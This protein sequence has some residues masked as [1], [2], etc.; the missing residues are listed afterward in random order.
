MHA[1][2]SKAGA[3]H[4]LM[5]RTFAWALVA[6]LLPAF[7]QSDD[8][9]QPVASDEQQAPESEPATPPASDGEPAP[10]QE[11]T[12][13]STDAHAHAPQDQQDET[14]GTIPVQSTAQ[15]A[16]SKSEPTQ[17]EEIVVT[18]TKREQ[19]LREIPQSIHAL[20]GD[21]LEK[22][23]IQTVA[24]IVKLTPGVNYWPDDG[25]RAPHI[26][27]RGISS[28]SDQNQTTGMIWENVSMTDT[29]PQLVTLDPN[30]FDLRSVEVLKG[31]Q[32]T[33]FGAGGFGGAV[34]FVPEPPVPGLWETKYFAQYTSVA[35]GQRAPIY[36]AAV[37]VPIGN[38]DKFALRL[39]G[40]RR[41]EPGFIDDRKLNQEDINSLDQTSLRGTLAWQPTQAWDAKLLYVHQTQDHP[42]SA[43]ADNRDGELSRGNIAIPEPGHSN[44]KM[45]NFS[46][47]YAFDWATFTSDSAWTDKD[48]F[49]VSDFSAAV[50][51]DATTQGL[52]F[53]AFNDTQLWS[54]ELRLVSP[55]DSDSSWK[56]VAGIFA[57][58]LDYFSYVPLFYGTYDNVVGTITLPVEVTEKAVFA[59]VTRILGDWEVSLGARYYRTLS[60]GMATR[61]GP[62]FGGTYVIDEEIAEKG[63]S[64][65]I[66]IAWHVTNEILSYATVA[67]GFRVGGVQ[68]G[69]LFT[70]IAAQNAPPVFKSDSLWNYEVG[71]RTNWLRNTL[72]FDMT[73]FFLDWT[74]AQTRIN[75]PQDN[76]LS[77]YW[78]NVGHVQS[79]G[80]E[81]ALQWRLPIDGLSLNT[82]GA[83]DKAVTVVPFET[84]GETVP[85]G[86]P[87]PQSPRWQTA[88]TLSYAAPAVAGWFPK[89]SVTH[90]YLGSAIAGLVGQALIYDYRRWDL[91]ISVSN[92]V[93]AWLPDIS[94]IGNNL[95]DERGISSGA[96]GTAPHYYYITPRALTVRLSGKF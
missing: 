23:G 82:S 8:T 50:D 3:W 26:T 62:L 1:S 78:T 44:F 56:W 91:N 27:V 28:G 13:S 46:V 16:P 35:D 83:Y 33:L 39:V 74:D 5:G 87:F 11:A 31:P 42:N 30:P 95:L 84:G 14:V 60:G 38:E 64:P 22:S 15:E 73:A 9:K 80:I 65:K 18:S 40:L 57:N 7:A 45:A 21:F 55:S 59:D 24:D 72:W 52:G 43:S 53:F 77:N 76:N 54:Q 17:L 63:V 47:S 75:D 71:I 96:G 68:P 88:T 36:G 69:V 94:L 34:R 51:P 86:T 49:F 81:A 32:G 19:S 89:A 6:T 92:P 12:S 10:E 70:P 48:M 90:T 41:Q 66:S 58:G 25:Q 37:N 29:Y 61:S 4:R 79:K 67:R 20:D 2:R 85:A 93:I